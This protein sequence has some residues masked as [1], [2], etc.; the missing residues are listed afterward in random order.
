[1]RPHRAHDHRCGDCAAGGGAEAADDHQGLTRR[2]Q[3][4]CALR[5]TNP[6]ISAGTAG[7]RTEMPLFDHFHPPLASRRHWE[8][9]H[10]A[11]VTTIVNDLMERL[12]PPG[13]FAEEMIHQGLRVEIDVARFGEGNGTGP[14]PD[15]PTPASSPWTPPAPTI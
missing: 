13:Y 14:T 6:T 8:S 4:P 5:K 11:W 15:A 10:S 12:L 9:F 2:F 3:W 1:H 7:R